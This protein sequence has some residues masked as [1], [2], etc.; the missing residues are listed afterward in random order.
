M[1]SV[2]AAR[3]VSQAP[4]AE[5]NLGSRTQTSVA[6]LSPSSEGFAAASLPPPAVVLP[7]ASPLRSGKV[8]PAELIASRNPVYPAIAKNSKLSGNVEM[9]FKIGID[10]NVY[11]PVV[12]KGPPLLAQAALQALQGWRY[13][14][15]SL[16]GSPI[17]SEAM[18]VFD[19]KGN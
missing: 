3:A 7:A 9:R 12:V 11:S 1:P 13:K 2:E 14:P 10:G 15:A 18:T 8:V 6:A 17:E 16:D 19:F 5:A 4:Q